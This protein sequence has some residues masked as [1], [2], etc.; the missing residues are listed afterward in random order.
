MISNLE[1]IKIQDLSPL[2][3]AANLNVVVEHLCE[4]WLG[5]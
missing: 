1:N 5:F 2:I 3:L 4:N